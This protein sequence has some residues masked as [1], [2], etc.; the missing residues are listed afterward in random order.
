M[1]RVGRD[2]VHS[3]HLCMLESLLIVKV[4]EVLQNPTVFPMSNVSN[5]PAWRV[6]VT[7]CPHTIKIR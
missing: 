4:Y 3:V 1:H 5:K 6:I 2:C 7:E